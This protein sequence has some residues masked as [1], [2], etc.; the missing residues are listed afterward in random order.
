MHVRLPP[1]PRAAVAVRL[2]GRLGAARQHLHGPGPAAEGGGGGPGVG[3][4]HRGALPEAGPARG[5]LHRD[6]PGDPQDQGPLQQGHRLLLRGAQGRAPLR[7]AE[8]ADGV[9]EHARRHHGHQGV[10]GRQRDA[11]GDAHG[12][13]APAGGAPGREDVPRD[14][15]LRLAG[16]EPEQRDRA[17][18]CRR[19][20]PL[21]WG[22]RTDGPR[23]CK[24]ASSSRCRRRSTT[25]I[26]VRVPAAH[27]HHHDQHHC[28]STC[29]HTQIR[30]GSR[31]PLLLLRLFHRRAL[32]SPPPPLHP[33]KRMRHAR[34]RGPGSRTRD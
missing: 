14:G 33:R 1:D 17:G 13:T 20:R 25:K 34:K 19:G 26:N 23:K 22:R 27:H 2:G 29:T 5:A 4:V 8:P 12:G 31:S 11:Q 32:P 28:R 10:R 30:R 16:A 21:D 15:G 7:P 3:G 18:E 24:N 9:R 6:R